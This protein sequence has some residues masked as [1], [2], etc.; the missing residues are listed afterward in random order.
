MFIYLFLNRGKINTITLKTQ[1]EEYKKKINT[2][3]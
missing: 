2:K 1:P 3:Y